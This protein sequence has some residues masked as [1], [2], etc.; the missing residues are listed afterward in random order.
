MQLIDPF[1][2]KYDASDPFGSLGYGRTN[3]HTGS[4]WIVPAG[5]SVPAIGDGVVVAKGWH[6]GNG[7]Y[8][9]VKLE[10]GHYFA[11]LHLQSP[12][13]VNVGDHVT[14]GQIIAKSGNTGSNS[15]GAHLHVTIS[16]SVQ[17][18]VGLG[19][20]VN[21]YEF[22]QAHVTGSSGG[23]GGGN[24]Y[25]TR[26][27]YK[28]VQGGYAAIGYDLGPSGQDGLEGPRMHQIVSDFQSKHGLEVDGVHGPRTEE[29]LVAAQPA[30]QS[31]AR[32]VLARGSKGAWVEKLQ[33]FG[34]RVYPAYCQLTV[35]GDFG[36]NTEAFVK[37]FQR[38]SGLRDDGVVG[39]QTWAK[40]GL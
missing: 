15:Q 7:N 27:Q 2:G 18:Y 19:N 11:Y 33:E 30:A 40:L 8:V 12:A 23:S 25:F 31:N 16:D 29:A 14:R 35:D 34:N 3:G 26:E 37:E 36:G 21:P 4:D 20:K 22:I 39:A 10:D 9:S 6:D 5:S 32:P 38:R 17:A 13:S 1:P 24:A 28:A